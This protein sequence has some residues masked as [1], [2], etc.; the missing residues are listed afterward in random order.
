MKL[1]SKAIQEIKAS[2]RLRNRL[3]LD[4]DISAGTLNRWIASNDNS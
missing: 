4:M 3:A 1:T 2:K